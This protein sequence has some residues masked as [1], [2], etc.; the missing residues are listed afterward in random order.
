VAMDS[1]SSGADRTGRLW[2]II[3]S[4]LRR[5]FPVCLSS[6]EFHYFPHARTT[7]LDGHVWDDFSSESVADLIPKLS[8]WETDLSEQSDLADH[9]QDRFDAVMIRRIVRTLREQFE[10]VRFHETQPTF[11]LTIAAI[12]LAEALEAGRDPWRIRLA[13]LPGF[14]DR[15]RENLRH[16]PHLFCEQGVEMIAKLKEWLR[17]IGGLGEDLS[18]VLDAFNRLEDHLRGIPLTDEFRPEPGVYARIA[19]KH[20]GCGLDLDEISGLLDEEIQETK[21]LLE[22]TSSLLHPGKSWQETLSRIPVPVSGGGMAEL[23]RSTIKDLGRHCLEHNLVSRDIVANCPIHVTPVPDY[24]SPVRSAAAYS[25]PP[26]HPPKGGTFFITD[27]DGSASAP[28]DWRL[29]A[30]HETFPGHHLMDTHRWRLT[31]TLRRYIEFPLYYE[32]WASFSEEVLFDTGLFGGSVDH[33]LMAKRRFWRAMRGRID[34]D[35]QTGKKTIRAAAEFMTEAGLA[36]GKARAMVRRYTLKPGY[37]ISCTIGR[38][39]FRRLY[40]R[41]VARGG[42]PAQFARRVL[43]EGEI[44]QDNLERLLSNSTQKSR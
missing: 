6:D 40:D 31:R 17:S 15:A 1:P 29:L 11:H 10:D 19:K 20:I 13:E 26:G 34:F 43:T 25:M 41:F 36:P 37:Q 7:P 44:G 18:A 39:R 14:L 21:H 22:K 9:L 4:E 35:I 3:L 23:Y 32:G 27:A 42:S 33:L 16:I 2:E 5:R 28:K 38:I 24:L 30:A 12:G 8:R